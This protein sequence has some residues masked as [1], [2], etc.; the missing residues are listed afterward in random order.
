MA[1]VAQNGSANEIY[2]TDDHLKQTVAIVATIMDAAPYNTPP[3]K[4]QKAKALV[5]ADKV[6]PHED[7]PFRRL[8][9]LCLPCN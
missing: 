6:Q 4:L 1:I 7:L 2:A 3:E 5:L 9:I 8:L